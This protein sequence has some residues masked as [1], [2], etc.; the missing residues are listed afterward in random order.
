MLVLG[1]D[2]LFCSFRLCQWI[3]GFA[4]PSCILRLHLDKTHIHVQSAITLFISGEQ[5][6]VHVPEH[7][8]ILLV[9]VMVGHCVCLCQSWVLGFEIP[10]TLLGGSEKLETPL[11]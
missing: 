7:T 6:F 1:F 8:C 4:Y 3:V 5:H 10:T 9:A 2:E 11:F